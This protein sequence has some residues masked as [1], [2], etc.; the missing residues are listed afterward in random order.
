MDDRAY[1]RLSDG[2]EFAESPD[3][4]YEGG[5]GD[6][7]GGKGVRSPNEDDQSV[8]TSGSM[9]ALWGLGSAATGEEQLSRGFVE[10]RE[11]E[12]DGDDDDLLTS[13]PITDR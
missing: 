5:D 10:A 4:D 9:G 7:S 1:G 12:D 8:G 13:H 2:D 6:G 11:R 3:D